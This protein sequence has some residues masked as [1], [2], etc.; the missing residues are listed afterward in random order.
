MTHNVRA[1]GLYRRAGFQTEGMRRAALLVDDEL[2][3]ELWMAKL[4]E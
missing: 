4:L 1:I 2:A 3:D